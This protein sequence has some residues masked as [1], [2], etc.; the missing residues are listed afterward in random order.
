M[1]PLISVVLCTYNRADLLAAALQTLCE[2]SL[3]RGEY[4]VIVVDN[5]STDDTRSVAEGFCRSRANVRYVLETRQGLSHARNRGWQEARG[6]YVAYTD[7]DCK[8]PPQWLAVARQIIAKKSPE[9]FGG[10]YFAFYN[11]A[12]PP[13]FK[14]SY[15]S[16][17]LGGEARALNADEFLAGGNIF[18][19]RELLETLGGF[20][21]S[22]G[23]AGAKIAYG[24]ETALQKR[25]R[26]A[27]PEACIYYDPD[28][29]VYHLVRPEK[30]TL[31]W[32]ARAAFPKG[33]SVYRVHQGDAPATIGKASMTVRAIRIVLA[34]AVDVTLGTLRRD[35]AKYPYIQNYFYEHTSRYLHS[36]GKLYA[37][38]QRASNKLSPGFPEK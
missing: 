1:P 26:D 8:L 19:R 31:L 11:T 2:Q 37:Q 18:F 13:W 28:L 12:K 21:T 7:D 30:M 22:L 34:F 17:E 27:S 32:R 15:G 25:V 16:C 29:Y 38:Y 10:P 4:E 35:R 24:E 14:D 9:I 23:M 20:D 36:L 33:R 5:N 3:D 6:E